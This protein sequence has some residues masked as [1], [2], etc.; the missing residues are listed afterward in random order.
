[1]AGEVALDPDGA[2]AVAAESAAVTHGEPGVG[3]RHRGRLSGG[4]PYVVWHGECRA[5]H[6]HL[7]VRDGFETKGMVTAGTLSGESDAAEL[8]SKL[9][10]MAYSV[11][12]RMR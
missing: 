6:I 8:A 9:R 1:M 3:G 11:I 12:S 4:A 7:D 2:A 5:R 10:S